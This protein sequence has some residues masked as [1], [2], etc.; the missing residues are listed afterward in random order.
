MAIVV[1]PEGL[2]RDSIH[3]SEA[4]PTGI[5][6]FSPAGDRLGT[7]GGPGERPRE[8]R[9]LG[10]FGVTGDTVWFLDSRL[11]RITLFNCA[12]HVLS[13]GRMEGVSVALQDQEMN[14][15][16]LPQALRTD[17]RFM[18]RMIGFSRRAGA[19]PSG[20]GSR[21]TAQ[22]PR[23]LAD[24]TGAWVDAIGWD[25]YPPPPSHP[26]KEIEVESTY[27]WLVLD[28]DGSPRGLV[29]PPRRPRVRWLGAEECLVVESDEMDIPWLVRLRIG[30]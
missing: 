18:G 8:F 26:W 28:A 16:A 9:T 23:I 12:G 5:R 7:I 19:E 22:V 1:C 10:W 29:E 27:R 24:P 13:T 3:G 25:G 15:E 20:I 14:G 11:R 6:V 4:S 2:R 30:P 17:D 21:D